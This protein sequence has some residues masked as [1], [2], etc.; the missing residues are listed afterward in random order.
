MKIALDA[1]ASAGQPHHFLAVT[2][3]GQSAIAATTGNEDCHIILR[4][5]QTPNY[6]AANV[7]AAS[8]ASAK[9]GL[10]AA[11]MIDASHA[12]SS[13]K[14]ENQPAVLADIGA[15]VAAG[16]RRI[17][18]VMVESNIVAGRQDLVPGVE[19]VYGQ[20]ITDGCIDWATTVT[21]LEALADSVTER[22]AATNQAVA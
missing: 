9:A 5:G 4:G 18:G 19:L 2:K 16:D 7:E 11:I 12:N 22:R 6:D 13:K 15:Q 21:T 20:S 14:P 1:V 17:I 8:A 10:T 3:D